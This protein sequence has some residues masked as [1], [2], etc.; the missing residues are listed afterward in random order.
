MYG[1]PLVMNPYFPI[2]TLNLMRG[3]VALLTTEHFQTYINAVFNAMWVNGKNMGDAETVVNVLTEAGLNASS[4][5]EST[6]NPEIK[7]A[8]ISNTEKAV[9]RGLF[10]A[11]TMFVDNQMFFG[12]DRLHFVESALN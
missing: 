4:I 2:N 10:G 7:A 3:A 8:L 1:L 9:E 11:P 12:Q 5:L 6:Q